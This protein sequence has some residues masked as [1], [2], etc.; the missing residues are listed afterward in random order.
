MRIYSK[1]IDL[2]N[3]IAFFIIL[4]MATIGFFMALSSVSLATWVVLWGYKLYREKD[5]S[6]FRLLFK[7]YKY[8]LITI[9]AFVFIEL[10]S[11]IFAV[12]PDEAVVG[13]KRYL[14]LL[15]FF[16]NPGIIKSRETILKYLM[17]ILAVFSLLSCVELYKFA[18]NLTANLLTASFAEIRIDYFTYPITNGEMKMLLMMTT[19]P[20]L[21]TKKTYNV[22]KKYLAI[23]LI[24][25]IL[26]LFLTQSRNVY[27]AVFVSLVIYGVFRNW[28]FLV[29]FILFI[30]IVWV[31]SPVSVKERTKS[32]F[33]ANHPSNKSRL[34]MWGVG[35]QVF[36]DHPVLGV[37]DN[38]ITKVYKLYK[39]PEFHGE[40]S[41]FHSNL[42]MILVTTG[43]AGLIFYLLFWISLF[44]YSIRD[45]R[46]ATDEFD[47]T[48]LWGI[49]LSMISFHISGIFEWNF[50]DW[51]V[52]TLLFY[53]ISLVFVLKN[54]NLNKIKND[55]Q[56]QIL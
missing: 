54:I 38:E 48:L 40:G 32:I 56:R 25:I 6:S 39:T 12:F 18:I 28:K 24:P 47:R 22:K 46:N 17:I 53:F 21:I 41:H 19:L 1:K 16:A 20:F 45:F 31:V 15:V 4:Q 51:E 14:L 37:G 5:A 52:A 44:Y 30:S 13:I 27:L 26:S 43:I 8:V 3:I 36:K 49:I 34:V 23:T 50:G 11:R 55:G 33:D 10:L 35:V 29:S 42:V 2:N 9:T 7:E